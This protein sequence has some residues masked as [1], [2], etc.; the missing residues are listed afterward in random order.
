MTQNQE[1]NK[2]IITNP[3]IAKTN[4]ILGSVY[5]LYNTITQKFYIGKCINSYK[6]RY[7]EHKYQA[8]QNQANTYLYK[9][10][11]K[12]GLDKFIFLVLFQTEECEKSENTLLELDNLICSKEMELIEFFNT[13]DSTIGYNLTNGGEGI[14]G[15]KFSEESK[16][17]MSLNRQGENHPRFGE[18]YKN[19]NAIYQ[20]DL[21]GNIV[22]SWI[23][24]VQA[25]DVLKLSRPN[26]TRCLNK[27]G[28]TSGG[29]LW[30]KHSDYEYYIN[31]KERIIT[32]GKTKS[33]DK[34]ILGFNENG[35]LIYTFQSGAEASRQ[36]NCTNIP[37]AA[38]YKNFSKAKKYYWIYK[39]DYNE[40]KFNKKFIK[41]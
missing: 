29:Y 18:K 16:L 15:Y 36:M 7:S 4:W 35:E 23:S 12:Y 30:V 24:T 19:G 26:I 27:I 25:S 2:L 5:C 40:E 32:K 1:L 6:N 38:S 17:Q 10:I 41:K 13:T 39:D 11:R 14:I 31:N 37:K 8:L 21:D 28:S 34:I 33:N 22:N 20:I 3:R 9:S